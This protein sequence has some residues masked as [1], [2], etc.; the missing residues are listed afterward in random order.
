MRA[1]IYTT[2]TT[3]VTLAADVPAGSVL[4]GDVDSPQT[5]PWLNLRWGEAR[6]G[7]G[8]TVEQTLTVVCHDEPND[9]Q[10]IT[11]V[12]NR[13]RVLLEAVVAHPASG[14]IAVGW[15]GDGIDESSNVRADI[16]RSSNYTISGVSL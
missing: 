14:V 12:L 10:R 5:T 15:T 8:G 2:V 1:K 16:S 4:A 6:T 13:V 9:Y 11:R 7:L 3:D